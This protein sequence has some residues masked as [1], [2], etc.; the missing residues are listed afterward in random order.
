MD[1]QPGSRAHLYTTG[2]NPG[3]KPTVPI[4]LAGAGEHWVDACYGAELD[5]GY[6]DKMVDR[7]HSLCPASRIDVV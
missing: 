6:V 2:Q 4:V 1:G 3:Y 7:I 5:G